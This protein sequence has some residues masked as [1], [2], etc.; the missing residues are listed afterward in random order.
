MGRKIVLEGPEYV[1]DARLVKLCRRIHASH[2]EAA[3]YQGW[4]LAVTGNGFYPE[5]IHEDTVY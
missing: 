5:S 3:K 2:T 4:Y 1:M